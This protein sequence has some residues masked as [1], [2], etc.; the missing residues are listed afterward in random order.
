M[1]YKI[2]AKGLGWFSIALG[3][4]E[5]TRTKQIAKSLD[6]EGHEGLIRGFG[7]REIVA[8]VGLLQSPAHSARVWNRVAGD[9]MDLTA[10]GLA[11]R[12]SPSNKAIWGAVAF[13]AA[14]TALDLWTARGL[15][16]TSG[17]LFPTRA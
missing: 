8:G 12:R 6:A 11:A 9:A 1:D 15:D 2:V 3:V 16:A 5:L 10:L 14:A 4:L 17:K 7:V 13:V